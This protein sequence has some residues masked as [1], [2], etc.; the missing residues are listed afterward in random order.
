MTDQQ[1]N[2]TPTIEFI[3]SQVRARHY[4][5]T[6]HATIGGQERGITDKDIETALLN[7]EVIES[8]DDDFPFPSCLVLGWR[9]TTRPL[10]VVCARVDVEPTLH[11]ITVYE[12]DDSRW[13]SDFKT[14]RIGR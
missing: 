2:L 10:H 13:L 11:I 14:R 9:G 5:L 7:G 4:D 1:R 3:Q 6:E 12:P 8:Y